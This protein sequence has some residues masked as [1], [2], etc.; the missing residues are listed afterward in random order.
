MLNGL[1][2]IIILALTIAIWILYHKLFHV[3]YFNAPVALVKE[4]AV[5]FILAAA[6]LYGVTSPI[7]SFFHPD[8]AEKYYGLF[9]NKEL[10]N[11]NGFDARVTIEKSDEIKGG[12]KIHAY[13]MELGKNRTYS[14]TQDIPCP[15]SK[16][17]SFEIL[18]SDSA[19]NYY[20]VNYTIKMNPKK[21]TLQVVRETDRTD[22]PDPFTGDYV[23]NDAWEK[24]LPERKAA[25][26][27]AM[28]AAEQERAAETEAREKLRDAWAEEEAEMAREAARRRGEQENAVAQEME[29]RLAE[30]AASR[31]NLWITGYFGVYVPR[32]FA[33]GEG[34]PIC[35]P[36]I[37]DSG[38]EDGDAPYFTIIGCTPR[39]L[40]WVDAF[41]WRIPYPLGPDAPDA[42]IEYNSPDGFIALDVTGQTADGRNIIEITDFPDAAYIGEY[43]QG[44]DL[45]P[46][47]YLWDGTYVC[48][49]GGADGRKTITVQRI[50]DMTLSVN[51]YHLYGDGRE[52]RLELTPQ[53]GAYGNG[54]GFAYETDFSFTLQQDGI[55][56]IYSIALSQ[57][58]IYPDVDLEFDGIYI[59][60]ETA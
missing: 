8:K 49:R 30:Q 12:I 36:L 51:L 13:A 27:A 6:I 41:S 15:D 25:E 52:E 43:I 17:V 48:E 18:E 19:H 42:H 55:T 31:P 14:F 38:F 4:F 60:Q 1:M 32:A 39:D 44:E 26:A 45:V 16:T 3:V 24:L 35:R 10:L 20:P 54:E 28:E 23:G 40:Q 57:A 53:I 11:G 5:C 22:I 29:R 9:H 2:G 7:R 59:K 46:N 47:L 56:G 50:D 37:L 34:E 21:K 33:E 58:H